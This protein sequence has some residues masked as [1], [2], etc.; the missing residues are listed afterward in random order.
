MPRDTRVWARGAGGERP[1]AGKGARGS[2]RVG[3]PRLAGR[4]GCRA[5]ACAAGRGVRRGRDGRGARAV[6]GSWRRG[7]GGLQASVR[8]PGLP[9]KIVELGPLLSPLLKALALRTAEWDR[10]FEIDH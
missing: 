1:P 8:L 10:S 5:R 7:G 4:L 6:A 2:G 9:A 3:E